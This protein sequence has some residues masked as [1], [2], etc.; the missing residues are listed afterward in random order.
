MYIHVRSIAA[1][2]DNYCT[3]VPLPIH[4]HDIVV[5]KVAFCFMF[6]VYM[7]SVLIPLYIMG[8]MGT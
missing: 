8:S 7:A 2:L 4:Y 1:F 5:C 3:G 6:T